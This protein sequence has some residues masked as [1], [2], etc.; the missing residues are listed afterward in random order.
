MRELA[1]RIA[2]ETTNAPATLRLAEHAEPPAPATPPTSTGTAVFVFSA[3]VL[4][5]QGCAAVLA[6]MQL[7]PGTTWQIVLATSV[8][9][10]ALNPC[11]RS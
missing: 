7:D 10:C 4:A 11:F 8:I 5:V 6:A 2:T 9:Q 3:A 1:P